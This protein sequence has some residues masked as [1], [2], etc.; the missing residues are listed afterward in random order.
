MLDNALR[1]CGGISQA[2]KASRAAEGKVA[3]GS[4]QGDLE[5]QKLLNGQAA[6]GDLNLAQDQSLTPLTFL[7]H[8]MD[9]KGDGRNDSPNQLRSKSS[10]AE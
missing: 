1:E 2:R 3:P 4:Q 7:D 6:P 9:R 8:L 5:S 10:L